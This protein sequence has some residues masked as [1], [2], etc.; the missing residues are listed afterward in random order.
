MNE[1]FDPKVF[2]TVEYVMIGLAFV[3]FMATQYVTPGYGIFYTKKWGPTIG[4]RL[5]WVLMEAPSFAGMLLVWLLSGRRSETVPSIFAV[6]FLAHYF[7]RTFIFPALIKSKGMMPLTIM[8]MGMVF[9]LVNVYLIGGWIFYVSPAG[10]YPKEWL[11]S[12]EMLGGVVIFFA[13]M[14]INIQSDSIIRNLRK[15]GDKR[16]YIPKGGMFRYVTSANYFGEVTEWVGYAVMTWSV[17]GAIFA[18]WTFANLGPRAKSLHERYTQEFGE[19]YTKLNR[20]YIIP[21]LW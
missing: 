12:P 13:G 9:N 17:P 20:R 8:L 3:V 18:L 16:H 15:P 19:E 2:Q 5:G 6:I 10:L 21:F 4:N 11:W 7:Q 1:I 14:W